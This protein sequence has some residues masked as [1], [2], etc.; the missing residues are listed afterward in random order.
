MYDQ[1]WLWF[2]ENIPRFR[3]RYIAI[4][5]THTIPEPERFTRVIH[6]PNIGIRAPVEYLIYGPLRT[7][8][9]VDLRVVDIDQIRRSVMCS[10]WP[11]CPARLRMPHAVSK[12]DVREAAAVASCFVKRPGDLTE[13]QDVPMAVL[14]AELGRMQWPTPPPSSSRIPEQELIRDFD[15]T[16]QD[17]NVI[18]KYVPQYIP[19]K[20]SATK[21]ATP[22]IIW[23][24][25]AQ[26]KLMQE[27]L[28]HLDGEPLPRTPPGGPDSRDLE[29]AEEII[30]QVGLMRPDIPEDTYKGPILAACNRDYAAVHDCND[31]G[32]VE[33]SGRE[34]LSFQYDTMT[35]NRQ[36]Q[37]KNAVIDQPVQQPTFGLRWDLSRGI[38]F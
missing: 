33:M 22:D 5:D 1:D 28:H 9:G 24:G 7:S 8:D 19:T 2:E 38:I 6:L 23:I 13:N 34:S 10:M 18:R 29:L 25:F 26:L 31:G 11:R 3:P 16:V 30:R 32:R 12:R 14:A 37:F 4:I 15:W 21:L 20:L 36:M 27:L 17:L 35:H